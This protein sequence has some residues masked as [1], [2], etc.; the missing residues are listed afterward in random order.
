[1]KLTLLGVCG[2]FPLPGA[3]CSSY[4]VE[5]RETRILLDCGSGSLSRLRALRPGPLKLDAIVL[6]HL[7]TDHAGEIDL[8]RYMLEHGLGTAPL[9]VFSPDSER[10]S[11]PVFEPVRIC[12]EAEARIGSLTLRFSAV[13]HAVPTFG[14][15]VTDE[16]GHS[17]FY[18]GDSAL[19]DGL[20]DSAKHADLLLA[21]ACLADESN[22][23][24][25]HNHMTVSQAGQ[26]RR[27]AECRLAVLTHRFGGESALPPLPDAA[28]EYAVEGTVYEI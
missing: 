4:L 13:K 16:S 14:V 10:V 24:A 6:S 17:L 26:L 18:T 7:H 2:P 1:M 15:R 23:K 11:Y 5:D 21:D 3:G 28:C 27:K 20:I 9:K 12:G 8:Y 22:E 19:F 25:L